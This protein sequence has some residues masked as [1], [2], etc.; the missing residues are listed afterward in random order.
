MNLSQLLSFA[1]A[2]LKNAGIPTANREAVWLLEHVLNKKIIDL[3]FS[4]SDSHKKSFLDLVDK[5]SQRFPLQ[6]L[7]GK[8]TFFDAE[9]LLDD[10][11]LIPRHETEEL[12]ELALEF[13]KNSSNEILCADLGTG[14][15]C[16]PV[17]LAKKIDNSS[18]FACDKSEKALNLAIKNAEINAVSD[19]I[20][21]FIS[22]WFSDFPKNLNFNFIIS[23]PPY[24]KN[25]FTLQNE[26]EYEPPSA[27]FSGEDGLDDYRIILSN[28]R[29]FLKK[30]G[31]FL[32][33]FGDGQTNQLIDI[34]KKNNFKDY[35]I[36]KDLSGKD[37]FIKIHF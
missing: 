8:T 17:A 20:N 33:E 21:F 12:V 5:R 19:K 11:V 36:L 31:V 22:N 28:L 15:G 23:N 13:L 7:I 30:N 35:E 4:V 2:Q 1:V 3:N 37:R 34:V 16:I 9:I 18:W 29:Y 25:N 32:G 14:S 6:Y 10:N 26:L 24:I 27:L